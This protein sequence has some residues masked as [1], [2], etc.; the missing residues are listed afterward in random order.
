MVL[1][2]WYK[3]AIMS[4]TKEGKTMKKLL[5][6]AALVGLTFSAHAKDD[7]KFTF[8]K[9]YEVPGLNAQQIKEA[10]GPLKIDVGVDAMKGF[11]DALN[12]AKGASWMNGTNKGEQKS[13]RCNIS[14]FKLMG[15]H[16]EYVDGDVI[17]Q[18]KDNK[19]RVT[20]NVFNLHGKGKISC[21]KSIEEHLDNKFANIKTLNQSW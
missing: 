14:P 12:I 17:L 21:E 15:K 13:I 9:I 19:A 8:Q 7:G 16:N 4:T 10:F 18:T 5:L 1:T 3:T 20:V 6:T 11:Q 2:F